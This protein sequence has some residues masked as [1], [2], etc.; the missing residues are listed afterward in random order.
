MIIN[1]LGALGLW[2]TETVLPM[3]DFVHTRVT[4]AIFYFLWNDKTEQ[5]KRDTCY[6]SLELGGLAVSNPAEK[7]PA[8]QLRW[9]PG[10][11]DPTCV[12]KCSKSSPPHD[13]R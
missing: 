11:S 9:V 10:I 6:L 1:T 3:P 2:Y 7:A 4:K 12:L 13:L 8:L 5:V